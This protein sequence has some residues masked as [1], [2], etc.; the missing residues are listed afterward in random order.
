[1]L[2][3]IACSDT[4][5]VFLV[6]L[7]VMTSAYFAFTAMCGASLPSMV[8]DSLPYHFV[9]TQPDPKLFMPMAM[10]ATLML[11]VR[12]FPALDSVF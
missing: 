5:S 6:Q 4:Q 2:P 12:W 7:T 1:M 8:V 10:A 3:V 9:L 11:Q